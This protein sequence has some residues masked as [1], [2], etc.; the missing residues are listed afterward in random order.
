[1][2]KRP[3]WKLTKFEMTLNYEMIME[4]HPNPN[5]VVDHSILHYEIFSQ[6][7]G[8]TSQVTIRHLFSKIK[9]TKGT[10]PYSPEHTKHE[11]K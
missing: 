4:R 1:M 9:R 3:T 5:E 7:D 11:E 10:R 2:G 8:K 6:L